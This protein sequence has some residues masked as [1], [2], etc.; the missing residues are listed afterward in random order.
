MSEE[1]SLEY[2]LILARQAL[3]EIKDCPISKEEMIEKAFKV[4]KQIS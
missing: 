2:K 4:L 1:L 3:Y